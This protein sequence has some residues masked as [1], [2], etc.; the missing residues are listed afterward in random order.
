MGRNAMGWNVKYQAIVNV[1]IPIAALFAALVCQPAAQGQSSLPANPQAVPSGNSFGLGLPTHVQP[2]AGQPAANIR[3]RAMATTNDATPVPAPTVENPIPRRQSNASSAINMPTAPMTHPESVVHADIN[4]SGPSTTVAGSSSDAAFQER[5]VQG[6][7]RFPSTSSVS[8][9]DSLAG[10]AVVPVSGAAPVAGPAATNPADKSAAPSVS[11]A[12]PP[13]PGSAVPATMEAPPVGG[14]NPMRAGDAS[15][16]VAGNTLPAGDA[17]SALPTAGEASAPPSNVPANAGMSV[18][19]TLLA[20]PGTADTALPTTNPG[21]GPAAMSLP[22]MNVPDINSSAA[23]LPAAPGADTN[24]ARGATAGMALPMNIP[25]TGGAAA[26]SEPSAIASPPGLSSQPSTGAQ[27]GAALPTGSSPA[28]PTAAMVGGTPE[29]GST[30]GFNTLPRSVNLPVNPNVSAASGQAMARQPAEATSPGMTHSAMSNAP[31]ASAW[32]TL[33]NSGSPTSSGYPSTS[34]PAVAGNPNAAASS[35]ALPGLPRNYTDEQVLAMLATMGVSKTDPRLA[36]PG[37]LDDV[38][39]AF[40][41]QYLVPNGLVAAASQPAASATGRPASTVL[42]SEMTLSVPRPNGPQ[43]WP[44]QR[45][46][47]SLADTPGTAVNQTLGAAA[48]RWSPASP[49]QTNQPD[50]SVMT[51]SHTADPER[52]L[53]RERAERELASRTGRQP[54]D[55][56][57]EDR[58]TVRPGQDSFDDL[59]SSDV[60]NVSKAKKP[61]GNSS[62]SEQ[63]VSSENNPF[64]SLLLLIS[65]A[66]NFFLFI[67]L[68]RVW[69]RHRDLIASTRLVSNESAG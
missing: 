56:R 53:Q 58:R 42:G 8:V 51:A 27:P 14:S 2:V 44:N 31:A 37:F 30:P 26:S 33:D 38:Y 5:L 16:S 3:N 24:E 62:G 19:D 60:F 59:E 22:A 45:E 12:A 50:R 49:G 6:A 15:G 64:V 11:V 7:A 28:A 9:P 52:M 68:R 21:S 13:I 69:Y 41:Q 43:S 47:A 66:G 57:T 61:T 4:R 46:R 29:A 10:G 54:E 40:Y 48:T 39:R 1:M 23:G 34:Y 32:K 67:G 63:R 18:P 20:L 25:A 36:Q 17:L 65:I 35:A 55:R